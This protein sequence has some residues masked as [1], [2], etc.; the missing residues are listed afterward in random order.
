[1]FVKN[2]R[3]ESC[4]SC[5]YDNNWPSAALPAAATCVDRSQR[6]TEPCAACRGQ[7]VDCR[8]TSAPPDKSP[9]DTFSSV[10]DPAW[11]S[12]AQWRMVQHKSRNW[13]MGKLTTLITLHHSSTSTYIPKKLFVDGRTFETHFIRWPTKTPT[14]FVRGPKCRG[15]GGVLGQGAPSSPPGQL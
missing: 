2:S 3:C 8:S 9:S 12:L 1:M 14:T 10:T 11:Q 4:Q 6:R 13:L 5:F 7:P 15:R